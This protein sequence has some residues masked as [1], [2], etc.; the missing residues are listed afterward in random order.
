M[1]PEDGAATSNAVAKRIDS[2][3]IGCR[4]RETATT[5]EQT[6]PSR[7]PWK[8]RLPRSQDSDPLSSYR[9]HLN[10]WRILS[11]RANQILSRTERDWPVAAAALADAFGVG[12]PAIGSSSI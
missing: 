4:T 1:S 10:S 7:F 2:Q 11:A 12:T 5:L 8:R 3:G 9:H 6:R